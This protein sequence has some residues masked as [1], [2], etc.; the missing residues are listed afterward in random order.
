MDLLAASERFG[1]PGHPGAVRDLST[2][3]YPSFSGHLATSQ[4]YL[5]FWNEI[6]CTPD[7]SLFVSHT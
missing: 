2:D 6:I 7:K 4:I 1:A 5:L 3:R